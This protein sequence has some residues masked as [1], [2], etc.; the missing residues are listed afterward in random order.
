MT[1]PAGPAEPVRFPARVD[2]AKDEVFEVCATLALAE[3]VLE[4]LGRPLE[5]LG[6]ARAFEL[7]EGRLGGAGHEGP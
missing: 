3:R 2:F 7:M 5:A 1:P 6:A 4:H